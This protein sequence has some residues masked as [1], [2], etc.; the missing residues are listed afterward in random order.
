M[1]ANSEMRTMFF[2]I[3][4]LSLVTQSPKTDAPKADAPTIKPV[5]PKAV[6]P[7]AVDPKAAKPKAKA[8][9]APAMGQ[10]FPDFQNLVKEGER[11]MLVKDGSA[12]TIGSGLNYPIYAAVEKASYREVASVAGNSNLV[13]LHNDLRNQQRMIEIPN[14][15]FV[16]VK[17]IIP[18]A[19]FGSSVSDA[20]EITIAAGPYRGRTVWVRRFEAIRIVE[21][22]ATKKRR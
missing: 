9:K 6:D 2:A 8:K 10:L 22:R 4:A 21:V 18:R 14:E 3:L 15:T 5:D 13:E 1:T 12:P 19:E 17:K 16:I 20:A 11:A 7:K